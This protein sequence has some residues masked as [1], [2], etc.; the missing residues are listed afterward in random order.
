MISRIRNWFD[1]HTRIKQ[2]IFAVL[3]ALAVLF[4]ALSIGK[5]NF[6]WVYA[7]AIA[8]FV[9]VF[10]PN[11]ALHTFT[12]E[13]ITTERLGISILVAAL[14]I[15][16]CIA[17]MASL[18]LWNGE[19]PGH[20]NQYELMAEAILD[21]RVDFAYGDE[22]AL[23]EL[24]NP[25]DPDERKE[26]GV[27]Y[28]WDHAYYNGHYYMY[29]GVVPV[30]LLFLPYRVITG[31]SM[32]TYHATQIFVALIIAGIFMLFY[33]LA[34]QFFKKLPFTVYLALSVAFSVASVW[35]SIAEPALYCTAIT[36]AIA[37]MVWSLY[38]F[39]KA[40]WGDTRENVQL[41]YA[42]IGALLGALAF[43]CRP[44][45][46]LANIVV[47]PLL[48]T[49]LKQRKFSLK[50]LGKLV[51]VALPYV[52][53]AAGLMY[54]NYIRFDDPF[55]FGQAYQLTTADQ[56][57]YKITWDAPTI[58]RILND[59]FKNFFSP[60]TITETFPYVKASSVFFNFPMFL[61][62]F[63][64]FQKDVLS[65]MK[66]KTALLFVLGMFLA[67]V[68][69]TAIDIVWT[70]YLLERYRMDIYFLI[71]ITCFLVIGFWYNTCSKN[72]RK[73]F[74]S[75]LMLLALLTTVSAFL[76]YV[77]TVGSYYPDKMTEIAKKLSLY[78]ITQ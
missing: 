29:F 50:L 26:T 1:K 77:R 33:F 48:I 45:I 52:V 3:I 16:I 32:T 5:N 56:H 54:Y 65:S 73:V 76:L 12:V 66:K 53:V 42:T 4:V 31:E 70:P 6:L 67:P 24:E 15:C 59:S 20:R 39:V 57:L 11:S 64:I 44:P 27:K 2:A 46:A 68:I 21:G 58:V 78:R 37:L 19:Q 28:H 62:V 25:Y 38:F 49:F 30:F 34:K 36:A 18:S 61:L 40:V 13:K 23:L 71:G 74:A 14:T 22:D 8:L 7:V 63:A 10:R 60:I 35:Y 9:F 41:I 75:A 47:L 72:H 55:E 69:I 43:G 17:P 51:L